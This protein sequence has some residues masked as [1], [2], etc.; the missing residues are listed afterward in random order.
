MC[1]FA[2]TPKPYMPD[3]VLFQSGSA[4]QDCISC[5]YMAVERQGRFVGEYSK[6]FGIVLVLKQ[7][8]DGKRMSK[9]GAGKIG[10]SSYLVRLT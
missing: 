6:M 9:E 7:W 5:S 2:A 3:V 4:E 8:Q 10:C 1:P